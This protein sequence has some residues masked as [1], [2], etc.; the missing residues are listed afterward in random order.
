MS[1][2]VTQ[3]LERFAKLSGEYGAKALAPIKEQ[4]PELA[5]FI[6]GTAYGDIFQ[7]TIITDQWKEVAIISSLISMGQYEQLGVH[8]A[9]ALSVGVT[10]DQLKGILLHLAPC[11]GAPR[12]ISAFNVL[13]ATLD[14]IQ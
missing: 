10:V 13:L 1:E 14:E 8:Y 7:R 12:I 4:F 3:G 5:E 11:V 2:Q 6:M 9:M